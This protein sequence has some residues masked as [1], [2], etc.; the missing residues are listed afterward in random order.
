[1]SRWA[2]IVSPR[3]P[4][5]FC[6][7][8]FFVDPVS[9]ALIWWAIRAFLSLSVSLASPWL[10]SL[11]VSCLGASAKALVVCPRRPQ[12]RDRWASGPLTVIT[13][14]FPSHHLAPDL[15]SLSSEEGASFL[16]SQAQKLVMIPVQRGRGSWTWSSFVSRRG[17]FCSCCWSDSLLLIQSLLEDH[18]NRENLRL[19]KSLPA[20]GTD[21]MSPTG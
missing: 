19:Q 16:Q 18:K 8:A 5:L 1:M 14:P 3:F 9:P 15:Y 2:S 13:D 4:P 20:P 7:Y 17:C 11:P 12:P 10:P 21:D 6:I